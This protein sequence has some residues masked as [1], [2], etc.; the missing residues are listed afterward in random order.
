MSEEATMKALK[1]YVISGDFE[2]DAEQGF[3]WLKWFCWVV[4]FF[5]AIVFAPAICHFSKMLL[6]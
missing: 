6:R 4:I 5:S 2:K 3:G 1:R